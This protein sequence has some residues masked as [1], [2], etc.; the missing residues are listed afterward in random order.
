MTLVTDHK[1]FVTFDH[2]A[3]EGN[4]RSAAMLL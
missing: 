3:G 2:I 4:G 1:V